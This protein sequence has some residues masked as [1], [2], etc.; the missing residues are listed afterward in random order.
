MF[1]DKQRVATYLQA[2]IDEMELIEKMSQPINKSEDFLF[3][4]TGMTIFR[5]CSMSLQYITE[6]F[7]KIRNLASEAFFAN[8][9]KVPWKSVFGMRNF[10]AHEYAE[11]DDEAVF[12]TIKKDLPILKEVSKVILTDL[13]NGKLDKYFLVSKS[14]VN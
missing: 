12:A 14:G 6:N 8:Y 11:I 3:D 13:N 1:S 4:I 9:K 7:I 2:A 5:A 10:L